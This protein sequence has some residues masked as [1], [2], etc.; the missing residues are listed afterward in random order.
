MIIGLDIGTQSAKAVVINEAMDVLGSA[1]H[2]YTVSYPKPGWAEQDPALWESALGPVIEAALEDANVPKDQITTLGLAG[3]LD[4]AVATDEAGQPLH[5]C[6]IWVDKRATDIM[7]QIP[8]DRVHPI[9]GVVA[10]PSHM[11]AKIVW[12]KQALGEAASDAHYHQPVSWLVERLTGERVLDHGHASTTMLYNL[13]SRS[14]SGELLAAFGIDVRELPRIDDSF[15][16]AGHLTPEGAALT[17]LPQG[18]T[19]AV[20]TG[21]DFSNPL[22]AGL[23]KPGQLACCL[24]TAEVVGALDESPKID[25]TGLLQTLGYPTGHY[26]IENPGWLSGGSVEWAAGILG[27]GSPAELDRAAAEIPPGS[28]GVLFL[29]TLGGATAPEWIASA[30][31]CFYGLTPAHDRRHM[32]RAVL[33]GC[34]FAMRDVADRLHEMR[35][36]LDSVFL[37]GGGA[38]SDPW[39]QIRADLSGLPVIVPDV[40]DTSPVGAAVLAAVAGGTYATVSSAAAAI[41]G[42]TKTF[43]PAPALKAAYDAAHG[44]YRRLFESLK[45]VFEAPSP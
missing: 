10:D 14:W 16:A 27:F 3:Q 30:R 19:V 7:A 18:V 45:P 36:P 41:G 24:G 5:P 13:K 4:G 29:P 22:G 37:L 42:E 8:A 2:S 9:S 26:F 33:E 28:D 20:G 31:G 15:A 44:A 17:G 1:S 39:A 12:L 38:R 25:D 11:A 23:A 40:A 6:L 32:A 34:A 35:V 43:N 21:D